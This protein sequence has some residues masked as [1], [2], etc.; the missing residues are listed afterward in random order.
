MVNEIHLDAIYSST[1]CIKN[2]STFFIFLNGF[3]QKLTNYN[4]FWNVTS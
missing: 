1:L 4:D 2:V 3:F